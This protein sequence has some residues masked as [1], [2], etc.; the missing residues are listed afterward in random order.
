MDGRVD[1]FFS[2]D[3]SLIIKVYGA[4]LKLLSNFC[5]EWFNGLT[6]AVKMGMASFI[7]CKVDFAGL[8]GTG[9]CVF[10]GA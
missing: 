4:I 2:T 1:V 5:A 9:G 10:A 7:N 8:N 3:N 6:R